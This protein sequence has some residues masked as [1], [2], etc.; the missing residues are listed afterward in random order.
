MWRSIC[1]G[2]SPDRN[3]VRHLH[4]AAGLEALDHRPEFGFNFDP[5]HLIWQGVDP[6]QFIRTFA[7]RIYHVHVKDAI[8]TL[9]GKSGINCEPLELSATPGAVGTSA[10]PVV[11]A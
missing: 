7:D 9:D 2:S 4:G 10:V 8:V 3:R 1:L 5:S 6:V 11:A